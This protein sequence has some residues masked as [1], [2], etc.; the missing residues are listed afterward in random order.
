MPVYALPDELWFPDTAQAT[1]DGLLA[2]GGDLS[3]ERLLLAYRSGIFP[4][5]SD[6]R[7][8]L[9][10][11]P[12]PRLILL[13]EN[14]HVGR[15][16][17]KTQRRAPYRLSLDEAFP[18]VIRACAKAAR[19]GQFGTWI[20]EDMQQA[21]IELHRRGVAHSVEAWDGDT[22]VGGLYGLALG[23]VFFGESM[24]ARSPDASKLAFATL[25]EQ[26]RTWGFTLVDC[27]VVTDH[28]LRFGAHEVELPEFLERLQRAL[29]HP[30]RPGPWDWDP[31]DADPG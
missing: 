2:V 24:F 22:L 25:V 6:D 19:P 21:Y 26:L 16:L 4:W 3:P 5:Y 12:S 15:S 10:W 1:A 11:C 27:Q 13:P 31:A 23:G 14:L 8:I 7:P 20:T 18:D 30:Q 9:W 17:R 29:K 28:L